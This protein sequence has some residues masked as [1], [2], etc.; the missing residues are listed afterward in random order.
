MLVIDAA[1][2]PGV[3]ADIFRRI[4]DADVNVNFSYVATNNRIVVGANNLQKVTEVLSKESP[5][6]V[7]R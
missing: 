7:R 6:A 3:E 4:A 2:R 5:A 1:D